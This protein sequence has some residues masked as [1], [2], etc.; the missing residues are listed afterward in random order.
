MAYSVSQSGPIFVEED[1]TCPI[2]DSY[3]VTE[4]LFNYSCAVCGT[5]WKTLF[6]A[7][8]QPVDFFE[9]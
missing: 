3:K 4:T 5:T 7:D 2:C 8:E 9:E 6:N 1:I